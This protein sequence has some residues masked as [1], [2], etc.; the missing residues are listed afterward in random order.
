MSRAEKILLPLILILQTLAI[1]YEVKAV[2][3][4]VDEPSHMVSAY[5][6]WR[7]EDRLKPGDMPPFIKI[8]GGWPSL[9]LAPPLPVSSP[10]WATGHE[11]HIGAAM[12]NAMR[13]A[14]ID[15]W[16]L[17]S[18]APFVVIGPLVTL[19]LWRWARRLWSPSCALLLAALWALEPTALGHGCLFKNDL[20]ATLGYLAFWYAA[21]RF[22]QEPGWRAALRLSLALSFALL[23]KISMLVLL[24]VA[25]LLLLARAV[26]SRRWRA[27]VL[28]PAA[29]LL[30]A[31]GI[32]SAACLFDLRRP[33]SAETLSLGLPAA[34]QH[35]PLPARYIEG[36]VS[37]LS[38]NA[39]P[40]N[41]YLFGKV[42]EG[43]SRLYFL[44]A[45]A[46]KTPVPVL[47]LLA[48][49]LM[50]LAARRASVPAATA[51]FLVFPPFFY[52]GLAS[53]SSLQLGYRLVLPAAPFLILIC[54]LPLH[55]ELAAG[56]LWIPGLSLL[57]IA[58]SVLSQYPHTI[59][60]F[61]RFASNP[62]SRRLAL[63]D[64]NIDWG[65]GLPA[66]RRWCLDNGVRRIRL[67]Y[68]G[69]DPPHRL[70]PD[71]ENMVELV[72]PPWN[73]ELARGQWLQP[74]PGVWAV[75]TTLLPGH[76]F[77]PVYRDYYRVFRAMQPEAVVAGSILI[78]RVPAR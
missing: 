52:I 66:L 62:R 20:S 26:A 64:S 75:S 47:L 74:E 6:Y 77:E 25:P 23:T 7:G 41:V 29:S 21:W 67:S 24:P 14:Q 42:Y 16:I 73:T 68:F 56:R 32:C 36:T 33:S 13:P 39:H 63:T 72:A 78:Y 45:L 27:A 30:A 43:G 22:W 1:A 4:T 44:S 2:G 76:M 3:L 34:A 53:L 69:N 50:L 31:Y 15:R 70:F 12:L 19:L 5:M 54:G 10:A 46:L 11:W 61:N 71:E 35:L 65:H 57:W 59:S 17:W 49:G 18:R 8:L 9:L 40:N 58:I 48:A 55:R 60:F 51:F 28:W 38:E 37:L